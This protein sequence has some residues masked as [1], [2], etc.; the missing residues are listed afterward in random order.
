[1]SAGTPPRARLDGLDV[2]RG[3]TVAGMLVVNTP[4][5]WEH[6][7]P[8]LLH[9][10]WHGWTYTDTIFPFFLFAVGVSIAL[11]TASRRERGAARA[12]LL[13]HAL[14]RAV[15]IFAIGFAFN[16]LSYFLFHRAHVRIPGVLQRIAVCYLAAALVY[17]FLG[18]RAVLP[19][20]AALLLGYWALLVWA[21][22]PGGDAG[23]LDPRGSFAAS[24]DRLVLG[25]HTWKPGWD[26]EGPLSTL[27]AIGTTL[28]GVAAGELLRA[29]TSLRAK[30]AALVGIGGL[31]V[32]VGALWGA[33]F[34]INKNLWTS[35]YALFMA[36]LAALTL[37]VLLWIV[38]LRE[39]RAWAAPF[40]WLG[41]NALAIFALSLFATLAL[42]WVKLPAAGGGKPRSL[43]GAIY[44]TVFDRFADPRLSS[45][46]F[47][48][49]FL[50]VFVAVAGVLYRKRI[51]VKI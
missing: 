49:A 2:F 45:L 20:A 8:P 15:A 44:R 23:R 41:T 36:G 27:P 37:A 39:R 24:V 30:L 9:A 32:T 6:V 1:L 42:L 40:R 3:A 33:V 25:E 14:A 7:F 10:E 17:L 51:F 46:L 29:K 26:P 48:L 31:G 50:S 5:T 47:A 12:G 22:V 13:R 38:D 16:V 11:S 21:P 19:A 35:S 34:P 43:Y 18:A 4:G 28:F